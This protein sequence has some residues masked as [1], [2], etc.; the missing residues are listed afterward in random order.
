MHH[1]GVEAAKVV[2]STISDEILVGTDNLK[3]IDQ[4]KKI[5]PRP[6]HRY[7]RKYCPGRGALSGRG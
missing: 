5:A 1:A 4:I 3:L 2:I 6:D 7:C